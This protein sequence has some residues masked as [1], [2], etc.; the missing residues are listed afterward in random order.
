[1]LVF[2]PLTEKPFF[3][4]GHFPVIIAFSPGIAESSGIQS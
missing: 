2:L 4:K 1:M 3:Q